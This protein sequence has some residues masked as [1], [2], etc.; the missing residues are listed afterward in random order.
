[1][2]TISAILYIHIFGV[3]G[4]GRVNNKAETVEGEEISGWKCSLC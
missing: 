1:M 3:L 2:K 4:Q